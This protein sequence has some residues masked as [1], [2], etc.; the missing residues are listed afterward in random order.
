[1]QPSPHNQLKKEYN[2]HYILYYFYYFDCNSRIKQL[3]TSTYALQANTQ[4]F[5]EMYHIIASRRKEA[6]LHV[7][8]AQ[9][10]AFSLVLHALLPYYLLLSLLFHKSE[11]AFGCIFIA[12]N[13]P[14]GTST[15][16]D[17]RELKPRASRTHSEVDMN[18]RNN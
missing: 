16:E 5:Y 2:T 9:F 10:M 13:L 18:L 15:A 17:K 14:I 4:Q 7:T 3:V 6:L 8:S 1:M 11:T 12:E